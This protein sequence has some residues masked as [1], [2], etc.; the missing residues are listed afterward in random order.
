MTGR[1]WRLEVH[2]RLPSTQALAAARAAAGEPERLAVLALEQTKGRGRAGRDWVSAPGNLHLTA[3]LRPAAPARRL[4]EFALLAAVA[5]HEAARAFAPV[6]LKWPNDLLCG[7]AKAG[8]VLAEAHLAG[9]RVA[10]LLLGFGVNLASAPAVPGRPTAR[11]GPVPAEAFAHRILAALDEWL[12]RHAQE[13]FGPVRAAWMA[14]GPPLG[15]VVAVRQGGEE[16]A[17]R[18]DGIGADGALRLVTKQGLRRVLA[19][20]V[21]GG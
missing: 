21:E 15:A 9:E 7:D 16:I 12:A 4:G 8:G 19:G 20:E 3:L 18:Y 6:R 5:L 17:G 14:A 13:G 2:P 11:L 10:A 1:A